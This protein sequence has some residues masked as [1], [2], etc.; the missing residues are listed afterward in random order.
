MSLVYHVSVEFPFR[1]RHKSTCQKN[2]GIKDAKEGKNSPKETTL[3]INTPALQN[4]FRSTEY[5]TT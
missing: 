3:T 5:A 2:V 4:A 1:C